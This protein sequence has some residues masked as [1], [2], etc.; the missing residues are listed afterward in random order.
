M[1][2]GDCFHITPYEVL[3]VPQHKC[4]CCTIALIGVIVDRR[5]LDRTYE[6]KF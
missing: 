4:P 5:G 6:E 3:E 1:K 2:R